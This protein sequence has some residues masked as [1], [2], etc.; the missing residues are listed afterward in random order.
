MAKDD[1]KRARALAEELVALF[2]AMGEPMAGDCVL[3]G[4]E[5]IESRV[6]ES[7]STF[8]IPELSAAARLRRH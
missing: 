8:P 2:D 4:L 7:C 3:V 1:L 6:L 5:R